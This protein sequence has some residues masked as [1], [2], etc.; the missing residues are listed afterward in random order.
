MISKVVGCLFQVGSLS[1]SWSRYVFWMCVCVSVCVCVCVCVFLYVSTC[2]CMYVCKFV[3]VF[4]IDIFAIFAV[5]RVLRRNFC[6]HCA[7][8]ICI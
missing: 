2:A 6:I 3:N 5:E 4:Y 8:P 7:N 1:I